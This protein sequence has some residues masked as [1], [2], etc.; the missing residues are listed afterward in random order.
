MSNKSEAK[1]FRE[2]ESLQGEGFHV[3]IEVGAFQ[4]NGLANLHEKVVGCAGYFPFKLFGFDLCG[5]HF[6]LKDTCR[7]RVKQCGE[8]VKKELR[9]KV[10]VVAFDEGFH[11]VQSLW[12]WVCI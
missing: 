10:R 4:R 11:C 2:C 1:A 3:E 12:V 8:E 6:L 7:T 9:R 5:T